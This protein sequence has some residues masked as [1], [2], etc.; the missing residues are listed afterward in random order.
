M[1]ACR[2][3]HDIAEADER[4]SPGAVARLHAGYVW[5]I[6]CQYFPGATF[7]VA[8][9]C[10]GELHELR[11]DERR[12]HLMEMADVAA[13]VHHGFIARKMNYARG[14]SVA[15][16]RWWLSPRRHGV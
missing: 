10:V 2:S 14:N 12:A 4:R 8:W 7:Y 13:A 6:P 3:C 1:T 5:L 11:T 15:H 9:S 16:L